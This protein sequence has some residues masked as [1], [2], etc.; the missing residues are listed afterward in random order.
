[1]KKKCCTRCKEVKP[2]SEFYKDMARPDN[3]NSR[4]KICVKIA[5]ACPSPK[6]KDLTPQQ[7]C[8]AGIC[9]GCKKKRLTPR[10]WRRPDD[11][12]AYIC[13]WC[14]IDF[15]KNGKAIGE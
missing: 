8:E 9:P 1:M 3:L 4:C 10:P 13:S 6:L 7:L 2:Y 11:D 5:F 12:I 14:E 15:D